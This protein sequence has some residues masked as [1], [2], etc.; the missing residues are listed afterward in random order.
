M[1]PTK[2]EIEQL[3]SYDHRTGSFTWKLDRSQRVKIGS[4]AG[5]LNGGGYVQI[6]IGGKIFQAHRLAWIVCHGH[7][8]TGQIDH[9]N[10]IKNDNRI[11]NLRDVSRSENKQNTL[12]SSANKSGF[13]GVSFKS[14]LNKWYAQICLNKKK[15]HIG[16]FAN[17]EDASQAYIRTAQKLHTHSPYV[18][19]ALK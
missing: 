2:Y 10:R 3:L 17:K 9:I 13:K 11:E 4:I 14:E 6:S 16:Y 19:E 1:Y 7:E 18:R 5:G 12:L 8:A 15:I